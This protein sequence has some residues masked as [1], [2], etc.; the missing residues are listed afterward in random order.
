MTK[1]GFVYI[2]FCLYKAVYIFFILFL[3]KEAITLFSD[4]LLLVKI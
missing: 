2:M 4:K 1:A 3:D